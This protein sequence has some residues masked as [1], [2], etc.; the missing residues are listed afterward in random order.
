MLSTLT[1]QNRRSKRVRWRQHRTSV[2][3]YCLSPWP[4]LTPFRVLFLAMT[5]PPLVRAIYLS[6]FS[7]RATEGNVIGPVRVRTFSLAQLPIMLAP[8]M[9]VTAASASGRLPVI[10]SDFRPVCAGQGLGRSDGRAATV[11]EVILAWLIFR[12]CRCCLSYRLCELAS[13]ATWRSGLPSGEYGTSPLSSYNTML[14]PK[15]RT[16][17]EACATMQKP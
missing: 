3:R 4:L 6:L 5:V 7:Q 17:V 1:V 8:S 16:E 14:N 12:F 2:G 9:L 15:H 13:R 10:S 11:P